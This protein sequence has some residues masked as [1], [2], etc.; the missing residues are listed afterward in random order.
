MNNQ[1][2]SLFNMKW[3]VARDGYKIGHPN[4]PKNL[5][6]RKYILGLTSQYRFEKEI[7]SKTKEWRHYNP[8]EVR[9]G[10]VARE[11]ASIP[12]IDEEPD[13]D[14]VIQFANSYG[15]LGLGLKDGTNEES[16]SEWK[17]KLLMFKAVFSDIDEDGAPFAGSSFNLMEIMPRMRLKISPGERKWNRSLEIN[18]STLYGAMWL[19]VANEITMGIQMKP[20]QRDGCRKWFSRRSN[21]KYCSDKCRVYGNRSASKK[22]S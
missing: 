22:T 14:A 13:E 17:E 8:F 16:L 15:L 19:M 1:D 7:V 5:N 12:L 6:Q 4:A 2:Q 18:P 11:F 10:S 9:G 20:C 21:K 3:V